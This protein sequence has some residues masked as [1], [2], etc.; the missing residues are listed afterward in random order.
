[1]Q[2]NLFLFMI[3][4]MFLSTTFYLQQPIIALEKQNETL[5]EEIEE[6][7]EPEEVEEIEEAEEEEEEEPEEVEEV[8]EDIEGEEEA[9]EA[10]PEKPEEKAEIVDIDISYS[11]LFKQSE[12][13]KYFGTIVSFMF[14]GTIFESAFKGMEKNIKQ[15]EKKIQ[16]QINKGIIPLPPIGMFKFKKFDGDIKAL[17]LTKTPALVGIMYDKSGKKVKRTLSFGPVKI[18]NFKLYIIPGE[19]TPIMRCE[20]VIFNKGGIILQK[21]AGEGYAKFQVVL[22]EILKLPTGIKRWAELQVF[23]LY[24]SPEQRTLA[25]TT[26]LFGTKEEDESTVSIDFKPPFPFK[27]KIKKLPIVSV[28][29]ALKKTPFKKVVLDGVSMTIT[30]IPPSFKLSGKANLTN[31]NLG[32]KSK[33]IA[34]VSAKLGPDGI[35]FYF[36]LTKVELPLKLGT[37]ENMTVRV[38]GQQ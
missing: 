33:G 1:M 4:S 23:E 26:K 22:N 34:T 27:A 14:K 36:N 3:L 5:D 8:E 37:V 28:L 24:V 17:G 7:E 10:E 9:P 12:I 16:K 29:G 30:S 38:G 32:I 19:K 21:E 11:S 20:I 25:T 15:L 35:L 18:K 2:K 31:V 6:P 13:F